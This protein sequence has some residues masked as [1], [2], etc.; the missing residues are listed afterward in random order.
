MEPPVQTAHAT[1][2]ILAL[3]M[4]EEYYG[5]SKKK[6]KG[7]GKVNAFE[8]PRTPV[9]WIDRKTMVDCKGIMVVSQC[10]VM[11]RAEV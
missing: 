8:E 5:A 4:L 9:V 10:L 7:K 1:L 2:G 3:E 11:D 6:I